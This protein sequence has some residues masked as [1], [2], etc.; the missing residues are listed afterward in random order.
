VDDSYLTKD[1]MVT[2]YNK[3]GA[4]TTKIGLCTNLKN[5]SWYS[6]QTAEDFFPRCFK[7][8]HEEDK[9]AFI[10]DYRITSCISLLKYILIKY[11]GEPEDDLDVHITSAE[12]LKK[13]TDQIEA[14]ATGELTAADPTSNLNIGP[15][16]A[17]N[18][19][20]Q[21]NNT[22]TSNNTTSATNINNMSSN[23]SLNFTANTPRPTQSVASPRA[24]QQQQQQTPLNKRKTKL[25]VVPVEAVQFAL[26]RLKDHIDFRQ[27]NDLD[28]AE[29]M[30]I[31]DERWAKF[32]EW[33]Y[34]ACQ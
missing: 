21:T 31:S 1:Q 12:E 11:R 2:H 32:Y 17:N 15:I 25:S 24:K 33:F 20:Q 26:E 5:L 4:F 27:N 7:L 8:S 3:N 23:S 6:E 30:P 9:A 13:Y 19:Q 28:K 10:E 29:Q 34:A 18:T 22:S 16:G 14:T